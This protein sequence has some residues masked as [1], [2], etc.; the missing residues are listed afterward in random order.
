H[1]FK[2]FDSDVE[3]K[4]KRVRVVIGKIDKPLNLAKDE[5]VLFVG[6]CTS[7]NGEIGGKTVKIE[8]TYK[9][10]EEINECKTKS[11]D[12]VL[13]NL[14]PILKRIT[15]GQKSYIHAKGCTISVADQV[16]YLSF[17][18]K[19]KNPNYDKRLFLDIVISYLRMV[20]SRFFNII[21]S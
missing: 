16:H 21:R 4:M 11:N 8:S 20:V 13:K 1:I 19:I 7:F 2:R 3:H 10:K 6:N 18:G 17:L 9:T 5:K 12:M 15:M 14:K